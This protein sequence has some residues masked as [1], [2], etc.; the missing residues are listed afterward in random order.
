MA[1][2]KACE[3]HVDAFRGSKTRITEV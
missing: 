3:V 2:P 1:I